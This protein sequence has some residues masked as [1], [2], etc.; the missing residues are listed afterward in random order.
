MVKAKVEVK[1]EVQIVQKV[2]D[3][4]PKVEYLKKMLAGSE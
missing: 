1:E 4:G 2:P 3:P